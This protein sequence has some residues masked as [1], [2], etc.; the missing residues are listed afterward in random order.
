MERRTVDAGKEAVE[1][2]PRRATPSSKTKRST[3]GALST[4]PR[5]EV[6][7][8]SICPPLTIMTLGQKPR[9]NKTRSF[10]RSARGIATR[11]LTMP[12][13]VLKSL[14]LPMI[15]SSWPSVTS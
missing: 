5:M 3:S 13:A 12:P 8:G 4:P 10:A 1:G 14:N 15:S 6:S 7:T 11:P 9:P 2:K